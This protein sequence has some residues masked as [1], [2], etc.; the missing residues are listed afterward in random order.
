MDLPTNRAD[1]LRQIENERA[2]L[3]QLLA[4]L[5]EAQMIEPA[6]DGGWSIKD[7]LAHIAAWE[8]MM[9]E[10]VEASLRDET[11]DRPVSGDDWVDSLN[12][13]LYGRYQA[14]PLA[15]VR[16]LF[17]SAYER[18]YE[19]A[20]G[21]SEAELFEPDR[22]AWRG[23]SPLVVLVAANTCWHYREHREQ[24]AKIAG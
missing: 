17:A 18:A 23:G 8:S 22:F 14:M 1:L 19:T 20:S 4:T 9:V 2:A 13:S 11:P 5:A 3:E 24:I 15:D 12:D 10:W 6:L 16:S 7:V 21:L